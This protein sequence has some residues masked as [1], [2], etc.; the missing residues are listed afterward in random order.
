MKKDQIQLKSIEFEGSDSYVSVTGMITSEY[1]TY[2]S[3][4]RISQQQLN[5]L[6]REFRRILADFDLND[7]LESFCTPDGT[8]IYQ[9]DLSN[10]DLPSI[11]LNFFM[12]DQQPVLIRA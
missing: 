1:L 7:H 4:L 10:T 9:I 6:N 11:P 12:A 3:E 2:E 8:I 5:E